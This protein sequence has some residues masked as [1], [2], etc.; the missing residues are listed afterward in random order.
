M[1]PRKTTALT[2]R[3]RYILGAIR[4]HW[5]IHG[6]SPTVREIMAATGL[7]SANAVSDHVRALREKGALTTV[8]KFQSRSFIPTAEHGGRVVQEVE[9]DGVAYRLTI[10]RID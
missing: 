10:E 6:V 8:A 7:A 2:D 4:E 1:S 9:V 5:R 3:Q